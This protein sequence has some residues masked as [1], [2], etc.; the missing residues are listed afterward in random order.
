MTENEVKKFHGYSFD[1][2]MTGFQDS[3]PLFALPVSLQSGAG[4]MSV[5]PEFVATDVQ[6]PAM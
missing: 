3:E 2:E 4:Q 5:F 6:P 1:F